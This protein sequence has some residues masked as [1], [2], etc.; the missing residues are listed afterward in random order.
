MKVLATEVSLDECAA[1]VKALAASQGG[2]ISRLLAKLRGENGRLAVSGQVLL[3]FPFWVAGA[4]ARF[5]SG[6]RRGRVVS[7]FMAVDGYTGQAGV[8]FGAPKA[9]ETDVPDDA[10]VPSQV[11]PEQCEDL[12]KREASLQVSRRAR[13]LP[14]VELGRPLLIHKPIWVMRMSAEGRRGGREFFRFIDG[15]TG[16]TV[17][18][19]DLET[20]AL[21]EKVG[22]MADLWD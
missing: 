2:A 16:I 6:V 13:A 14:R 1:R 8:A 4:V 21:M 3:Y 9:V 22:A 18:R 7:L 17:F 12:M 5:E 15:E 10:V 11:T 20:R 19:Y